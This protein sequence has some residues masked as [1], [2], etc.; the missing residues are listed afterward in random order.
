MKQDFAAALAERIV[1]FDGATGTRLYELGVF[2]N[3]C[4]DELNLSNA[5]LVENVH[6]SYVAAGADVVETNTFGANRLKLDRHGLGDQV[7]AINR[8]GASIARRAA[9]DHVFVAGAIG[10][11]GVRIEPWGPTSVDEAVELFAEQAGALAEGGVDLFSVETF[12]DLAE[13]EAAVRG[14]RRVSSLPIVAHMTLEDDGSSLEGVAPEVFGP[15][16][17]A[18]PVQVVGVNCSVGPAA[19]LDAVE[20]MAAVVALP[21]SAQPNAGKPRSVDNRNLYLCS[22]EYMAVYA[23]RF[24]EAGARVVGGCC[25]TTPEHI[26]AI[27]NAV[28]AVAPARRAR[29]VAVTPDVARPEPVQV[30]VEERSRLA[31]AI[32]EGRFVVSVEMLP[33]RGHDLAKTLSGAASLHQA[34]VDAINIP[35]GPRAT[36]RMSPMAMAVKLEREIGIETI[37]HYCCRDRNLLGMQSDLLGAHALGLRNILIITGDPPKL[38]DYPDATAVFDVDSIGLT[39]MATRLNRG[40]DVGGNEIGAPTAFYIGCGVNP[41]S[42]DLEREIARFEWK[43]DAGAQFCVTQPVFDVEALLRFLER[44]RGVRIPFIAGVWPLASYRNAEFMNNEVPGVNVP[45]SILERMRRADTKEKARVEGVAIA[46]EALRAL[47]PYVQGAQIS[48]PFGR[49]QTALDVAEAI[50]RERLTSPGG[51]S[52]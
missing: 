11:L 37:I 46:Q 40:L 17:A 31:H 47:L 18:L 45:D 2:L 8:E 22:P 12:Y 20:R 30:P 1:V 14:I 25:G 29:V 38:G 23:K 24:I 43:V 36:A 10:P 51:T 9:G 39:N 34:G 44:I 28:R 26:K 41:G 16:L 15:R 32:S 19:M 13:I 33:P 35:D 7:A 50:P 5:A 3:K 42:P 27:R 6:R 48:A 21:I 52:R 4:F 49:Y